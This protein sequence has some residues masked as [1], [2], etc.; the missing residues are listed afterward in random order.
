MIFCAFLLPNWKVFIS[1]KSDAIAS[2]IWPMLTVPLVSEKMH[3]LNYRKY[4]LKKI[5][6]ITWKNDK[7]VNYNSY[8]NC[9]T[10]L[11]PNAK[12]IVSSQKMIPCSRVYILYIKFIS[13]LV[14]EFYVY[15]SVTW[16]LSNWLIRIFWA[17][18]HRI[19]AN[20]CMVE[21]KWVKSGLRA[22]M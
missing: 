19:V 10:Q 4:S 1:C 20:P 14:W 8:E 11:K 7:A 5:F 9:W 16:W 15:Y 13:V 3:S 17:F 18:I 12:P 22:K 6:Q 2:P 21:E